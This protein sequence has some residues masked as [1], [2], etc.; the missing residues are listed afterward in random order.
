MNTTATRRLAR[1]LMIKHG[2]PLW[3]LEFVNAMA[4][5]G[6]TNHKRNVIALTVEYVQAYNEEQITQ[7]VLHEIAHA[8]R[9]RVA[10]NAH[11]EKWLFIAQRMGYTGGT[12]MPETYPS[13][14]IVWDY[15]CTSTGQILETQ[16]PPAD[17][18][19]TCK[20]CNSCEPIV[21]RRQIVDADLHNIPTPE[22]IAAHTI[23]RVKRFLKVS[24]QGLTTVNP[25]A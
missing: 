11:D 22:H 6:I 4:Y 20:L 9:G 15:T 25:R 13:P 5:A 21:E 23:R 18:D 7:L 12:C 10:V 16:E 1:N 14:R 3:R 24:P 17:N 8:I 19:D 2:V